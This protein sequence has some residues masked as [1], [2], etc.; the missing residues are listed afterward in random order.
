MPSSY[1]QPIT[2]YEALIAIS[3]NEYLLPA[4][5]RKFTWSHEQICSLFDSLM[6]NYPI[7]TFM[8]WEVESPE[9][10]D[11]F[12]FYKMLDNYCERFNEDN[13]EHNIVDERP[14]QAIIDGQ[15]RLTSINI[16]IRGTY[17]YKLPRKWW[18]TFHDEQVLPTRKL[19]LE[20]TQKLDVDND[21]NELKM[22]YNFKFLTNSEV[23]SKKDTDHWFDV[24]RIISF[25]VAEN[26]TEAYF[27]LQPYL[28]ENKLDSNKTATESLTKLYSLV[29]LDR[30]VHYYKE[31]TQDSDR[32]LDIFIRTNRGG[33][34]LEYSDLLMSMAVAN[35]TGDAK[36]QIDKLVSDIRINPNL[37][38]SIDR[39]YILKACLMLTDSDVK[40]KVRNFNP[41]IVTKI[42]TQ[43]DGISNCILE[44]FKLI[45]SWGLN[46][47]G[48]KAKNATIPI[49]YYL[50]YKRNGSDALYQSINKL[51]Q[52][53]EDKYRIKKWLYIS[54][55]KQVFG[56]QGDNILTRIRKTIK[57]NLNNNGFPFTEIKKEFKTTPKDITLDDDFIE[58]LVLTQ[59]E[60]ANCFTVLSMLFPDLDYTRPIEIDHLHPK[61]AFR[62]SNLVRNQTISSDNNKFLFYKDKANWNSIPNLHLLLESYNRSKNDTPLEQ[63]LNTTAIPITR[64]DANIP[65][66]VDLSFEKFYEFYTSRKI[67]LSKKLKDM[68]N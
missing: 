15:Q 49:A 36:K 21:D 14:F 22:E 55:L 25:G 12:K 40:F 46:D 66:E 52:H 43:W 7:N 63:W 29:Y 20:L 28:Q 44:T 26:I 47:Q 50:Y 33:T 34:Q 42:E 8:F 13:L 45:H 1:Q 61:S 5:Q 65:D 19:Y 60:D 17:A 48:L 2:I 38:Y 3:K 62:E 53:N 39:D 4:I 24:S 41:D 37:G 57:N 6:R 67:L 9:I 31:T 27:R 54:L 68:F 51:T 64:S 59:K 58:K 35:W 30:T 11:K 56:G 23:R 18:P 10:K 16:G 32:V